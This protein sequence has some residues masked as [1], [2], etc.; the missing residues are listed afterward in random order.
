[1]PKNLRLPLLFIIL[2][3]LLLLAR[4]LFFVN[5]YGGLEHDSGWNL[6]LAKNLATRGIYASYT[7]TITNSSVGVSGNI[8][9][10]I[11][12]QDKLGFVY[13][14][15]AVA[16]GPGY[17]LPEA[18]ILKIFGSGWWQYRAW[19]L[20]GFSA[21]LFL[22]LY[23]VWRFGHLF[24]L[25][26]FS[27]WLWLVPQFTV[28]MAYEALS[29][30]IALL[31]LLIGFFLFY[32]NYTHKRLWL[33]LLA[34]L[35][36]AFSYLTKTLF[37]L[38]A[39]GVLVFL[40]C[41]Y[42]IYEHQ[43]KYL[44]FKWLTLIIG[45]IIPVMAF[46]MYQFIY[47]T[48]HFGPGGWAAL[49]QESRLVFAQSGSG[50]DPLK[51]VSQTSVFILQKLSVWLDVGISHSWIVW[52][53]YLFSPVIFLK[54]LP[55]YKAKIFC[56]ALYFSSFISFIWFILFS[57]DGWGRHIWQ[58]L[59]LGMLLLS[60]SV[61]LFYERLKNTRRFLFWL[62]FTPLIFFLINYSTLNISPVLNQSA[63]TS[64]VTIRKI[65]GLDGFPSN[66]V[67]SLAD[68]KQLV[69]F[70]KTDIHPSD[71]IF[72]HLG[73]LNAEISPLV[74]KVFY[75]IGRYLA[76]GK[77]NPEGGNSYLIIGPYQQGPWSDVSFAY[78]SDLQTAICLRVVFRNPS[79]LLCSVK[80]EL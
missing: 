30:H 33:S 59:I 47:L 11:S 32:L 41:D 1:M 72:Y 9:N 4:I 38:P 58:G 22:M 43:K 27:V 71:R 40:Q 5:S 21:L 20:V 70:F 78:L 23:I 16:I 35:F 76:D 45:I 18:L 12:V 25:I 49:Q 19:P 64:W 56:S 13:F 63:I 39:L 44:L 57:S 29:E 7:N 65:R 80:P 10:R 53:F 15:A 2:I 42:F 66:P 50:T 3:G 74:D 77:K 36:I 24:G 62:I 79:Y 17:V 28:Q 51:L 34:G 73:Y 52:L 60:I 55:D 6:G 48:S 54:Y 46:G 37:L 67:L 14:P 26:I 75:P 61:G 8:H 31:F 68:Q 69:S